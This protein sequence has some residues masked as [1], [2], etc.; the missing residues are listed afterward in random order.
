MDLRLWITIFVMIA[1]RL[2]FM[3]ISLVHE[4]QL[5]TRGAIEFGQ[6]NS[7]FLMSLHVFFYL[8]A[9]VEGLVR[10]SAFNGETWIGLG[11]YLF[12]MGVLF[13]VVKDLDGIWTI[14]LLIAPEFP[15][16]RTFL[17]KTFRHPNYFLNLIPEMLSVGLVF[18][19]WTVLQSLF[20]LYLFSLGVRIYQEEK[21]MRSLVPGYR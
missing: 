6:G 15:V 14:K 16:V 17:F 5:R 18:K 20:P 2:Y 13:Q 10:H 11:L 9:V 1:V 3:R 12:A 4:H 7:R 21:N 8:A 19:A